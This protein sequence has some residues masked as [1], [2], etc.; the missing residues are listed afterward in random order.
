MTGSIEDLRKIPIHFE[1]FFNFRRINLKMSTWSRLLGLGNTGMSTDYAQ[2]PLQTLVAGAID[3]LRMMYWR[4]MDRGGSL[5][6]PLR[7]CT[8]S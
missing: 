4:I 5:Q 2:N 3:A 7:L 1:G 8:A 6:A